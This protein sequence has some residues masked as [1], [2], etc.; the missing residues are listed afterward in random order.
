MLF[1][2]SE[3]AR[4][5]AEYQQLHSRGNLTRTESERRDLLEDFFSPELLGA[6]QPENSWRLHTTPN[7]LLLGV[8]DTSHAPKELELLSHSYV[9]SLPEIDVQSLPVASNF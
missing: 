5:L 8:L 9:V 4:W 2:K 1:S 3:N 7:A 6:V